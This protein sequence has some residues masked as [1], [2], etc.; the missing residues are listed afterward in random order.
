MAPKNT[1]VATTIGSRA[2]AGV[3]AGA[4][5][6]AAVAGPGNRL[7]GA[8]EGALVGG[9]AAGA[10]PQSQPFLNALYQGPFR[11]LKGV[12]NAFAEGAYRASLASQVDAAVAKA[13]LKGAAAARARASLLASP[14]EPMQAIAMHDA[15]YDT[16]TDQTQLAKAGRAV[17]GLFGGAGNIVTPFNTTPASITTKLV[18]DANP[19]AAPYS[20]VGLLQTMRQAVQEMANGEEVSP[21]TRMRQ[22]QFVTQLGMQGVNSLPFVFG[23]LAYLHGNAS[24]TSDPTD[25][26]ARGLRAEEGV[27]DDAFKIGNHWVTLN[28]MGLPG[29]EA[30][31]GANVAAAF[32]NRDTTGGKLAQTASALGKAGQAMGRV[33]LDNPFFVGVQQAQKVAGGETSG[34][35]S[36]L[37][38]M[39]G[40]VVPSGVRAAAAVGATTQK[41]AL[42]PEDKF[43]EG[44]PGQRAGLPDRLGIFGTPLRSLYGQG[45]Q[46]FSPVKVTTPDTTHQ[47]LLQEWDRLGV[48]VTLPPRLPG[49]SPVAYNDRLQGIGAQI[50]QLAQQVLPPDAPYH[51]QYEALPEAEGAPLTKTD[52]W[53]DRLADIRRRSRPAGQARVTADSL[54]AA[55]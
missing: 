5:T 53:H 37:R 52:W 20:A 55:R 24:G 26:G 51:D 16:M 48:P 19:L 4:I 30:A 42:T 27:P 54:A 22:H 18:V 41:Q 21:A 17:Q 50:V 3:G 32:V 7:K 6:G 10:I 49:E 12:S 47:A 9:L 36:Y 2:I 31:L 44:I 25:R 43:T 1:T 46:A 29:M 33:A 11:L 14:T 34:V 45:L 28:R 39:A 15:L 23:A 38:S 40:S 35:R 13:G 8:G